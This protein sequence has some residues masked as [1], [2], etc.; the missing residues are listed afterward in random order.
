MTNLGAGGVLPTTTSAFIGGQMK[1]QRSFAAGRHLDR[2]YLGRIAGLAY[3][4]DCF[5]GLRPIKLNG[6]THDGS[7]FP[8]DLKLRAL[9]TR[10]DQRLAR[11]HGRRRSRCR[12]RRP[13]TNFS[14]CAFRLA[15]PKRWVELPQRAQ[16]VQRVS[17]LAEPESEQP[18]GL[19]FCLRLSSVAERPW[20]HRLPSAHGKN[21]TITI[22]GSIPPR[23]ELNR[24]SAAAER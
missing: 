6:V 11:S 12:S 9:W 16:P 17:R 5:P 20:S 4:Y 21:S 10:I 14:R 23:P 15:A 18:A 13:S 2:P 3:R 1:R 7:L 19:K 24:S 22:T 8:I